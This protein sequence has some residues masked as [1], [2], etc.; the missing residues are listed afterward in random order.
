[1]GLSLREKG[2]KAKTRRIPHLFAGGPPAAA[3][4]VASIRLIWS[5]HGCGG[6]CKEIGDLAVFRELADFAGDTPIQQRS[7]HGGAGNNF[8]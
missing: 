6:R 5:I 3:C 1:M 7:L 2:R 4:E 8:V